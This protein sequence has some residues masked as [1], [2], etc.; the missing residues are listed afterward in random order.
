MRGHAK[1]LVLN[2]DYSPLG[3]TTWESAMKAIYND[4]V[5]SV[6]FYKHD[7][8]QGANGKNYPVPAV[9]VSKKYV[10]PDS[11]IAYSKPNVF[12]RDRLTCQYCS[13]RFSHRELTVD[14]VIPRSKWKKP[15]SPSNWTNIVSAC[16]PCNNKKADMLLSECGM[17]LLKEPKVP[18]QHLYIKG[19]KPWH[20]LQEEWLP[21]LPKHFLDLR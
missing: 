19:L 3:I 5:V 11:E 20:T 8:I 21:Y 6:D 13:R 17:K 9:I 12:I 4:A 18:S 1:C 14:H 10:K 15:G 2:V 16:K 7:F